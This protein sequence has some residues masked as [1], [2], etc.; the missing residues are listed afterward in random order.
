M[1]ILSSRQTKKGRIDVEKTMNPKG[2]RDHR[3]KAFADLQA[4]VAGKCL[5]HAL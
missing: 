5:V 1:R 3:A 2:I 4:K